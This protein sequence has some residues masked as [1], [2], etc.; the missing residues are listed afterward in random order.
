MT[1]PAPET[2][3]SAETLALYLGVVGRA[4]VAPL[5]ESAWLEAVELIDGVLADAA[6]RPVPTVI[7]DRA[8]LEVGANLYRRRDEQS[9][10]AS[11][12]S[13]MDGAAPARAPRDPLG[14]VRALLSRYVVWL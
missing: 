5:V 14:T 1:E 6:W 4:D 10:N 2:T 11:Q 12:L 8:V 9:G 3:A 7:R 13:D